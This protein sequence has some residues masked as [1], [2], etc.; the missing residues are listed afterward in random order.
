MGTT[1]IAES[2]MALVLN[3]V[4]EYLAPSGDYELRKIALKNEYAPIVASAA[5]IVAITTPEEAQEAANHGRVLQAG[6]KEIEAFFKPVKQKIDGIKA[7]ILADEK[8]LSN[9]L[10][11]E[12][13]RIGVLQAEWDA[14]VERRDRER[15]RL[16]EEAAKK[17][18][19]DDVLQRAIDLAASGEE[20][21]SEALLSEPVVA[22]PVVVQSIASRPTGS[23]K[24]KYYKCIVTNFKAL[25]EAVAA[26]KVPIL[27]LQ[28]NE[29]F[30]NNQADQFK[31]GFS[32]PG[33]VLDTTT[34]MSYRS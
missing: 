7:P 15:Q 20:E 13:A 34:S 14:E 1:A 33:C 32:F 23:V 27:A 28:A 21:A 18:A 25:V 17:Q 8:A 2:S 12:K 5:K 24:R 9:P 29:S 16:A 30:L 10:E 6:K 11:T 4:V 22:A 3:Q 31:E 19:E 26:G